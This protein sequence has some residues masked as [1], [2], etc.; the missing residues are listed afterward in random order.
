MSFVTGV[1]GTTGTKFTRFN[2]PAEF[3]HALDKSHSESN[4]KRT[5]AAS[6]HLQDFTDA[7]SHQPSQLEDM[8]HFHMTHYFW[9]EFGTYL[10][11]HAKNKNMVEF[12]RGKKIASKKGDTSQKVARTATSTKDLSQSRLTD[13]SDILLK[14]FGPSKSNQDKTKEVVYQ[15]EFI[16]FQVLFQHKYYASNNTHFLAYLLCF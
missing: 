6:G 1:T 7:I 12:P 8:E 3:G 16:V 4:M 9:G 5:A 2:L 10:G 13:E 14:T 15:G 11:Q